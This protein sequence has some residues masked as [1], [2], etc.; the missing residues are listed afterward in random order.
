M[1]KL[2]QSQS[3]SQDSLW[4]VIL[5]NKTERGFKYFSFEIKEYS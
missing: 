5:V 1:I 3:I 4:L 2:E